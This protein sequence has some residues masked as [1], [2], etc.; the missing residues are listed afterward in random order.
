[1]KIVGTTLKKMK[2]YARYVVMYNN[3]ASLIVAGGSGFNPITGEPFDK[4]AQVRFVSA[5]ERSFLVQ[6]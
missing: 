3:N 6:A 1:M 4:T 2:V 5:I